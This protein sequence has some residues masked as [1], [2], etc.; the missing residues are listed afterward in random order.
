MTTQT[1]PFN[2]PKA[3]G[4]TAT[5][6][7]RVAELEDTIYRALDELRT[8]TSRAV[9]DTDTTYLVA[10]VLAGVKRTVETRYKPIR[11]TLWEKFGVGKHATPAG[12]TFSFTKPP[13][14]RK[15]CNYE[16]LAKY[17]SAYEAA[18]TVTP[19]KADA[20]GTLRLSGK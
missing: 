14:S 2:H 20:V 12:R 13:V 7:D 8:M 16:V 1:N 11:T 15:S 6:E 18:V 4:V 5:T 17:P 3:G 9:P 19:T 10:K